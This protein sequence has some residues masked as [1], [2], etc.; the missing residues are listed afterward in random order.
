MKTQSNKKKQSSIEQRASGTAMMA[1]IHRFLASKEEQ[2]YFRG[3]DHLARL[4][5]PPKV[6]FLLSFSFI[7]RYVRRKLHKGVPGTYE[8]MMARTRYFDALFQ[9]ALEEN[10]PQIVLLGAGCDTR[11]IRFQDAAQHTTIFELDAPT[12]QQQKQEYLRKAK[13]TLPQNLSQVP[14]NFS[15]ERIDA[16]LSTTGYDPSEK[17]LFLWEGVT[18]YLSEDAVKETLECIKNH[19]G[20][21][22][23]VAFDYFYKSFIKG[24]FEYYGAKEISESV[25]KFGEP[26]QFGIEEGSIESFLAEHGFELLFHY[27][28]DEFENTYLSD[29]HGGLF[30]KMYGFA[31]HVHARV[32][33]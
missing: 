5:L 25:S 18:Y 20:Y 15:K 32:K 16:V 13:I 10:T 27:T 1:A 11:A 9:R 23:S 31:C 6:K 21:G 14:I 24:K 28:P 22:S 30:G 4:F 8:Y 19:A 3:P 33:S 2:P 7:R 12:T 29:H 17:S 26:F